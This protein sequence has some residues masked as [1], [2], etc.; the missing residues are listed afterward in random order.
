MS[1]KYTIP[2][3]FVS[4]LSVFGV[5]RLYIK[6]FIPTRYVVGRTDCEW[7][8]NQCVINEEVVRDLIEHHDCDDDLMFDIELVETSAAQDC[9]SRS[10]SECGISKI[11]EFVDAIE[12]A[13]EQQNKHGSV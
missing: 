7:V 13:C 10:K 8:S 5:S 1:P 12:S 9:T 2:L 3:L 4:L 6:Y 11:Q